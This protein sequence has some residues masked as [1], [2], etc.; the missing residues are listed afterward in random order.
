MKIKYQLLAVGVLCVPSILLFVHLKQWRL[1]HRNY[2]PS[3]AAQ[4]ISRLVKEIEV[5][6]VLSPKISSRSISQSTTITEKRRDDNVSNT[7]D[8]NKGKF[9]IEKSTSNPTKSHFHKTSETRQE[10]I[11]NFVKKHLEMKSNLTQALLTTTSFKLILIYTP[12]FG[13]LPWPGLGTSYNFTH[14]NHKACPVTNCKITYNKTLIPSADVVIFHGRDMPS[15]KEMTRISIRRPGTQRWVYFIHESPIY[16]NYDPG[17]YNGF[18][19]WTMTYRR[20]SD[21]FVPYSHY[22]PL[23]ATDKKPER[24]NYA[25]GKDKLVAWMVG[26]CGIIREKYAKILSQYLN[27]DVYGTCSR[28]FH[29]FKECPKGST[30]CSAKLKRYKFYLSFEN[31][32]CVDYITEKYWYTPFHHDMVPVVFGGSDYGPEVAI[33]GSYINVLDF[34]TIESLANYLL[35]LHENDTAYNEY[36]SWKGQYKP[37]EHKSWT[38]QMCSMLN[39]KLGHKTWDLRKFWGINETCRH[40]EDKIN[41]LIGD[42][43]DQF[44]NITNESLNATQTFL[45][46]QLTPL[47]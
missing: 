32:Y 19:N 1:S 12:L 41:N 42:Y 15:V 40:Y 26:H 31:S 33:P 34:P 28:N 44:S 45:N 2:A 3:S 9:F 10:N 7:S 30:E 18:F 8:K 11:P 25:S 39:K 43:G 5:A 13:K 14:W 38:C 16:T 36:F 24:K 47:E 4:R 17:L 23:S 20:D 29:H 6:D 27:L 21:I 35:Y 37:V 46:D 22:A